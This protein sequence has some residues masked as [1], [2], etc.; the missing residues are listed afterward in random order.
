MIEN[1]ITRFWRVFYL[2]NR[3]FKIILLNNLIYSIIIQR[4]KKY[5]NFINVHSLLNYIKYYSI[6][7]L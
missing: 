5:M 3:H 4:E 1:K 6:I 2:N 7:I